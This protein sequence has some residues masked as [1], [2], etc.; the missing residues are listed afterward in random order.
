MEVNLHFKKF[1]PKYVLGYVKE[2]YRARSFSP[3]TFFFL[4]KIVPVLH[5]YI[6]TMVYFFF[7]FL[8]SPIHKINR[9]KY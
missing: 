3:S 8:F 9:K 7:P 4:A 2:L 5:Y 1:S 6:I